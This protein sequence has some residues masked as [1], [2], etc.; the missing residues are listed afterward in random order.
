MPRGDSSALHGVNPNLKKTV[1]NEKNN[2]LRKSTN[3]GK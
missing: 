1:N 3:K 2:Q